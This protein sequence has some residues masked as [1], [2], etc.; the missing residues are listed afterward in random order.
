MRLSVFAITTPRAPLAICI[1]KLTPP[2]GSCILILPWG[3]G[4]FGGRSQGVGICLQTIFVIFG[5]FIIIARIGNRQHF[6][7][8]V[9]L[10]F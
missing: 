6:G 3:H 8:F 4:F 1:E 10:I 2:R 9:A 7:L 5:I